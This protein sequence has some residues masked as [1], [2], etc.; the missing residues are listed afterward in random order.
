MDLSRKM[1]EL[2][3]LKYLCL[4]GFCGMIIRLP[5]S[6]EGL[7][8]LQTL[9]S[10]NRFISIPHTICKL[11][12]MRHLTCQYGRILRQSMRERWV[13]GHLDFEKMTNLQKLYLRSGDWLKDVNLNL[14]KLTS[15]K[16]LKLREIDPRSLE[17]LFQYVSQLTGLQNL[18]LMTNENLSVK[19]VEYC[20]TM[21]LS[22]IG[23]K[24]FS[25]HNCLYKLFLGVPVRVLL[26][27]T[28]HYLPNLIQLKLYQTRLE[29]DPMLVL[30]RLPNLRILILL[31][32]YYVGEK[33]KCPQGG[34]LVL[35]F[36]QMQELSQL[37]DFSIEETT[38]P[39][40]KTLKI[41]LCDKITRFPDG[42]LRLEKLQR[43]K[44]YEVP[45]ELM[46]VISDTLGEDWNRICLITSYAFPQ[47]KSLW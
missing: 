36:L 6:I 22:P 25:R 2:I 12:Q 13:H 38:T 40:L 15:L 20:R 30:G 17:G 32:N 27:E 16:Q 47:S 4:S 46:N 9:D 43:L 37:E 21:L 23:L 3:Q 45:Q 42:L 1:R 44:L 8:N 33:M 11:Q 14:G 28:T 34:F 29:E 26:A 7:V 41:E 39:N 19:E 5:P 35:Q 24:S 18:K 10:G 31:W